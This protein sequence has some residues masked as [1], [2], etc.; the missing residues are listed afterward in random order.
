MASSFDDA[1][2]HVVYPKDPKKSKYNA[3]GICK[4]VLDKK[5]PRNAEK[6]AFSQ[7]ALSECAVA[8]IICSS[9]SKKQGNKWR[10]LCDDDFNKIHLFDAEYLKTW[11][12]MKGCEFIQCPLCKSGAEEKEQIEEHEIESMEQLRERRAQAKSDSDLYLQFHI[13]Q[14]ILDKACSLNVSDN[15]IKQELHSD[16][17]REVFNFWTTKGKMDEFRSKIVESTLRAVECDNVRILKIILKYCR[18]EK[19]VGNSPDRNAEFLQFINAAAYHSSFDCSKVLLSNADKVDWSSNKRP[20]VLLNAVREHPE[21]LDAIHFILGKLESVGISFVCDDVMEQV[22][23]FDLV[24]VAKRIV[25]NRWH[26]ISE[27]DE[28]LAESINL[29]CNSYFKERAMAFNFNKNNVNEEDQLEDDDWD[30]ADDGDDDFD[31][32][33]DWQN[34]LEDDENG[35]AE[36]EEE[37]EEEIKG[38][39]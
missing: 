38:G 23:K 4:V 18:Y 27:K 13:E 17:L 16:T 22:I 6:C 26:K 8:A 39:D 28:A 24:D 20:I 31:E 12:E 10:Y 1:V 35:G 21:N 37:E 29:R 11:I 34:A 9:S 32:D 25:N 33:D 15:S 5:D 19:T 2:L 30:D 36:E 7:Y 14:L 3:I